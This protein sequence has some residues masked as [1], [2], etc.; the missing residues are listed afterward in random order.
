MELFSNQIPSRY[1]SKNRKRISKS[2]FNTEKIISIPNE[3]NHNVVLEV[4][5]PTRTNE[6]SSS[7]DLAQSNTSIFEIL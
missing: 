1:G 3:L 5:E 7:I 6:L 4:F 2:F